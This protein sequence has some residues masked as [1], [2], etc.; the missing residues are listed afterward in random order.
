MTN[1]IP[2]AT[3][4]KNAKRG[5]EWRKKYNRGGT[6]VGVARA[7]DLSNRKELSLSTVKR[8]KAY[9]D[10]HAVDKKSPKWNQPSAGKIAW[11]LWGGDAGYAWAKSILSKGDTKVK[12]QASEGAS[13]DLAHRLLTINEPRIVPKLGASYDLAK[14]LLGTTPHNTQRT[15]TDPDVGLPTDIR[16][17]NQRQRLSMSSVQKTVLAK[18]LTTKQRNSL[19][20]SVFAFPKERKYPLTDLNHA[21]VALREASAS[22]DPEIIAVVFKAVYKKFP[23][24]RKEGSKLMKVINKLKGK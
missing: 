20:S 16:R 12:V 15:D 1:M 17:H 8:M 9:F 5:L 4:A 14:R 13:Y 3:V 2:P 7:R 6:A 19:P 18:K 24:L 11:Y 10:R 22:K 23:E 21:K